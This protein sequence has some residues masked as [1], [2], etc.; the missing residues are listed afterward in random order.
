MSK[1]QPPGPGQEVWLI[2]EVGLEIVAPAIDEVISDVRRRIGRGSVRRCLTGALD[3]FQRHADLRFPG[4]HGKLFDRASLLIAAEEIHPPVRT[5]GIALQHLLDEADSLDVVRPVQ[6]GAKPQTR[7][8]VRDRH[9]CDA[10]PLMLSSDGFLGCRV[11]Q[12]EV[13][14][15]GDT[16]GGQPK[17]VLSNAVQELNDEGRVLGR[18]ER[19]APVLVYPRDVLVRFAPRCARFQD[20]VRQPA[21][22]LDEGELEHARPCPELADRERRDTLKAVQEL[23]QHRTIEPAVAVPNQLHGHRIH[24]RISGVFTGGES[25]KRPGI[26]ARQVAAD[27]GNLGSDEVEVVEQPVGGGDDELTGTDVLGECAIGNPQHADVVLEAGKR[28]ARVAARVGIEGQ[29]GRQRQSPAFE[30]LGAEKLVSKWLFDVGRGPP[31]PRERRHHD[32]YRPTA[33]TAACATSTRQPPGLREASHAGDGITWDAELFSARVLQT[34]EQKR[35]D[36]DRS[37]LSMLPSRRV[38]W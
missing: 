38:R 28:I 5:G 30:G 32:R 11:A 18:R 14:V 10:L 35:A 15:Y 4:R 26:R 1:E 8:G 31:R 24:A 2:G 6:R 36:G 22:V 3:R 34:F 21:Q 25:W 12:G 7:H 20:L 37:S 16:D 27:I 29:A 19:E 9:L 13:V 17:A 33:R 23:E